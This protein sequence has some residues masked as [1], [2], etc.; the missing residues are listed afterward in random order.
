MANN[1]AEFGRVDHVGK[2]PGNCEFGRVPYVA[3][4]V[5]WTRVGGAWTACRTHANVGGTWK[6]TN[7]RV[8]VNGEWEP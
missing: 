5:V 1:G 4:L 7:P 3:S 6:L 8:N 2:D